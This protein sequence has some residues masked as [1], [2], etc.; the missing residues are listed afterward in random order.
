MFYDNPF[1]E[2]I[3][4]LNSKV[5]PFAE[6]PVE[7][8][9]IIL[10][11]LDPISTCRVQQV[12][13][14]WYK[15]ADHPFIWRDHCLSLW[16]GKLFRNNH[17][18][19]F[20]INRPLEDL[21]LDVREIKELL[22]KNNIGY[23]D[24]LTVEDFQDKLKFLP[25]TSTTRYNYFD[26][27]YGVKRLKSVYFHSLRY[28]KR[29]TITR[30]ELVNSQWMMFFK[31][32]P[33]SFMFPEFQENGNYIMQYGAN[34]MKWNIVQNGYGVQV[35]HYPVLAVKR[36][37]NWGWELE[38]T[39]AVLR[40]IDT[41]RRMNI[42]VPQTPTYKL[43][44][45]SQV[46]EEANALF[47][48]GEYE[49]AM[50]LYKSC[51]LYVKS[52]PADL[53]KELLVHRNVENPVAMELVQFKISVC[54]NVSSCFLKLKD[55]NEAL[56]SAQRALRFDQYNL[57]ALVR[58]AQAFYELGNLQR[59]K[60]DLEIVRRKVHGDKMIDELWKNCEEKIKNQDK[61]FESVAKAQ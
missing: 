38:N 52:V 32:D 28:S 18:H 22:R 12:K 59:C 6:V 1:Q 60:M 10:S 40:T 27:V 58:R 29:Q 36:I 35:E 43:N 57:K 5:D 20:E 39:H 48:D 33:K 8:S 30:D 13:K 21:K 4:L 16:K 45:A 37:D 49:N 42:F 56:A 2:E 46:K 47:R 34:L 41:K 15:I 24:C 26:P 23:S 25:R 19:N 7:V 51:L 9:Q 54:L 61:Y 14:T 3:N 44:L 31:H 11:Y 55:F 53:A 17:K 50:L